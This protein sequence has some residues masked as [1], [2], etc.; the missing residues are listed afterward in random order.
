[1]AERKLFNKKWL[2]AIAVLVLIAIVV[3]MVLVFLPKDTNKAVAKV[4][5]TEKSMF[6]Q[7]AEEERLYSSF[8]NKLSVVPSYKLEAIYTQELAV[9]LHEIIAFYDQ[10]LVYAEGNGVFQDNYGHIMNGLEKASTSQKSMNDI[11]QEVYHKIE[12]GSVSNL[13]TAWRNYR[14]VYVDYISGC[15]EAISSLSVVYKECLPKGL[16][17]NDFTYKVLEG[18]NGFLSCIVEDFAYMVKVDVQDSTDMSSFEGGA[19]V[20]KLKSFVANYITNK[21]TITNYNFSSSLQNYFAKIK[22]FEKIYSASLSD[23]IKSIKTDFTFATNVQDDQFA[24][25]T[26]K[27]FLN[28]GALYEAV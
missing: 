4:H 12:T 1:M 5:E 21:T 7:S 26:V 13:R 9:V 18:V 20:T 8:E 24:L 16:R 14:K 22:S 15:S 19:K 25:A 28:G 6:L 11:L 27:N 17:H 10:N 23:V 2:I 3:T